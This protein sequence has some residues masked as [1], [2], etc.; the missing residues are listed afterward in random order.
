LGAAN[1]ATAGLKTGTVT[2]DLASNGSNSGLAPTSLGSQTITVNGSVYT[3][4]STWIG[5]DGGSWGTLS[6]GFGANW[7]ADQGSPGLD[8]GF[9][10]VDTATFGSTS[11]SVTVNLDG[12]APSLNAVT[13][14]GTGS[15]TIAQGS[16]STGLTLAGTTPAI[17]ATGA[18]VI[19]IPV[20]LASG[21][22][23]AVSIG[24]TNTLTIEATD[25]NGNTAGNGITVNTP[26][27]GTPTHT[28]SAKVGLGSSQTWTVDSGASLTVSGEV[29]DFGA[30]G[31]TTGWGRRAHSL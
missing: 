20:A 7:G 21:T 23:V 19:S 17:T 8:P 26:S 4:L 1:T 16:G 10:G 15:Y 3:G 25:A 27:S 2:I 29:S 30:G 11:G 14:N 24:G 9:T 6:S 18:Q 28:I 12:A 5:L 13:F 22:N 31:H